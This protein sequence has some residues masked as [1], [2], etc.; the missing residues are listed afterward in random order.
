MIDCIKP[1]KIKSL[2]AYRDCLDSLEANCNLRS[3]RIPLTFQTSAS[4]R[5][6][7]VLCVYNWPALWR[8]IWAEVQCPIPML[9]KHAT[10]LRGEM[11]WLSYKFL[12][13]HPF[14]FQIYQFWNPPP[15]YAFFQRDAVICPYKYHQLCKSDRM[16]LVAYPELQF[17]AELKRA[18]YNIQCNAM[19][20]ENNMQCA[21]ARG[22]S[23]WL[24]KLSRKNVQWAQV[25]SI[26]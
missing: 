21:W 7:E 8:P 5:A 14:R 3:G 19:W 16:Q 26:E 20:A 17:L 15:L 13:T 12:S 22:W 10:I 25:W 9:A 2:L 1:K 4:V 23:P 6:W 18:M 24:S 11:H